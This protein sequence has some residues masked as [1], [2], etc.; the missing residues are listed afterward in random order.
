MI[1]KSEIE[2]LILND[3][4][5]VISTKIVY[6]YAHF[7]IAVDKILLEQSL[8]FSDPTVFN[9]PFDCNEKLLNLKYD[10]SYLDETINNLNIKL[11]ES[12]RIELKRKFKDFN[13]Q[14]DIMQ[15]KREEYKLSCFSESCNEVLM[16]SHYANKH[17]GICVGFDFPHYYKDKFILCPVKYLNEIKPID[18]KTD[19]HRVI[20]YWLTTKSI[21]WK[22]ES[23]IRALT[24]AKNR[25]K[26]EFRNYEP[27]YVKEIIFGCNVSDKS[28]DETLI[29]LKESKLHYDTITIKRMEINPKDFLLKEVIIKESV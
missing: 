3:L 16:W 5:K 20:L 22:Y 15:K 2:N 18:G 12:D 6:Q 17:M 25:E 23:E 24:K 1:Y 13:S 14:S 27:N 29:K 19:V 4:A 9:D 21:R 8:R 10:E 7:D 28:I 11:S 26:H